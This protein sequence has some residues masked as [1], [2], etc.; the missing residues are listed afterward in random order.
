MTDIY[1]KEKRSALMAKVR[2]KNTRPERTVRSWLHRQGYRFRLHR[3]D[4]PGK[5]DIVLPKYQAVIFVHGCFWHRHQGCRKASTPTTNASMWAE[6]FRQ[7]IDRDQRKQ[8]ELEQLG[9]RVIVLWQCEIMDGTFVA[10]I[11]ANGL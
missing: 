4:L 3:Q 10:K 1:S 5:P 11:R 8:Q 9:W 2:A 7:N 6:K